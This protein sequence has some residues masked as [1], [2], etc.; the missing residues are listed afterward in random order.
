MSDR[1]TK[2]PAPLKSES[3]EEIWHKKQELSVPVAY[4]S[5][6]HN[7]ALC[8]PQ[9]KE[10]MKFRENLEVTTETNYRNVF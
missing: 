9:I 3:T 10:Y 2:R 7:I 6:I 1:D 8:E 5:E 4:A